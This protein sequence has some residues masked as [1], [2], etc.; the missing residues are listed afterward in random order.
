MLT[1]MRWL[2]FV[3]L[4]GPLTFLGCGDE[5]ATGPEE[6]GDDIIIKS[7]T[8]D[9]GL[10]PGIV[11]DFIVIVE[12]EL[13]SADSGEVMVGFNTNEVGRFNMISSATALV[14]KGSGEHQFNVT[15]VPKDWGDTGD[16]KVYVNLSKHPHGPSWTP[17]ATDIL[18][19]TIN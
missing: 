1:K 11:T 14:V 15:T 3:T 2:L 10:T 18:V 8:P 6:N 12:Y 16:F 5:N 17:L 4:V 13:T 9:S 19:L 7:I